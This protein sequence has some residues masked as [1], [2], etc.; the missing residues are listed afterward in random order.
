MTIIRLVRAP[1]LPSGDFSTNFP[2]AENPISQGGI[3]NNGLT[4]GKQWNNVRTQNNHAFGAVTVSGTDD[5]ICCLNSSAQA[6]NSDQEAEITIHRVGGYTAPDSH[7]TNMLLRFVIDPNGNGGAGSARGY[8]IICP[9]GNGGQI[10]MWDGTQG[11]FHLLPDSGAGWDFSS[12]TEGTKLRSRIVG[13][14][15]TCY[16]DDV[17]VL[18]A[19]DNASTWSDGKPGMGF[20]V[21]SG[22]TP[23]SFCTKN[24]LAR[25]L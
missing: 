4:D 24:F 14:V 10:M 8:E 18:T 9:F 19:T 3:W 22:G 20:F 2:A 23:E 11:G 17:Q 21:R 25:S 16:Q 7:E 13:N 1:R 6:F 12:I 5:T 15:I